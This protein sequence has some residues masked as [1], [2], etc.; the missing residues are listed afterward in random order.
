MF[1]NSIRACSIGALGLAL[2]VAP[3]IV[4]AT[5]HASPHRLDVA[6]SAAPV[7][8]SITS[9]TKYI[10]G[11]PFSITGTGPRSSTIQVASDDPGFPRGAETDAAGKWSYPLTD[12]ATRNESLTF[13]FRTID[14][15]FERITFSVDRDDKAVP[16][17]IT[18]GTKYIRGEAFTITGTGPRSSTVEIISAETGFSR[19]VKTDADGNWSY[20]LN[21]SATRNDSLTYHF[22]THLG[23]FETITFTVDPDNEPVP[24]AITSGTTYI[25]GEPFTVTGT[26]P[27][28]NAIE[29][30]SA[31][32]GFSRTAK[33]DADG[34]WAHE[35]NDSA[36]RKDSLTYHFRSHLGAFE[37]VT[38]T[39]DP[40]NEPVPFAVTSGT[41]YIK[42]E[43]FMVTGTAPRSSKLEVVS[44]AGFATLVD[45]STDGKWSYM[46]NEY[47]T[48]ADGLALRFRTH[49][50]EFKEIAFTADPD[51]RAVPLAVT[52]GVT[53]T[54]GE[55]FTLTGTAPRNTGVAISVPRG[56]ATAETD[57][58]G[59]WSYTLDA[60]LTDTDSIAVGLDNHL[61]EHESVTLQA[62]PDALAVTSGR[63]YTKGEPLTVTG[64][65]PRS[66][67]LEISISGGVPAVIGIRADGTWAYELGARAT[68]VDE[69]VLGLRPN[70]GDA[71]TVMLAGKPSTKPVPFAVTS[72]TEYVQ[73]EPFTITGTGPRSS[74]IDVFPEYLELTRNTKTDADGKWSY[75]LN[76]YLTRF[77]SL[78]FGFRTVAGEHQTIT[79]TPDPDQKAV[80]FA[81]TSDTTYGKG[82]AFTITGTA[83]RSTTLEI[84]NE[85]GVT[86]SVA[87]GA[88]GTWK[89]TLNESAT[90][91]DRFTLRFRTH[92]D[93]FES[94]TFTADPA[95]QPAPV[96]ITS[97][98]TYTKGEAFTI[99]GTAKPKAEIGVRIALIGPID[100]VTADAAGKWSLAITADQAKEDRLALVLT[101]NGSDQRHEFTAR[102][103]ATEPA[104]RL[105]SP[106]EYTKGQKITVTGK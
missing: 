15:E 33:T 91:R 18:S 31:E 72:G 57:A 24:F 11:E 101:A 41:T 21:D 81:I 61:G 37:T 22:R 14:D 102:D 9:G 103:E 38:F 47:A 26:G 19:T 65:G 73:G 43:P 46:L 8:F 5:A 75:Q 23:E 70:S 3:V 82:D 83:P 36:T 20:Q 92:L 85:H 39:V 90:N 4:P 27:R 78:T 16:L 28:S 104:L 97:G 105:T 52:S 106:T 7:P 29:I 71:K 25:K 30:I 96:V 69:L 67:P 86:K 95:K 84:T 44:A 50:G 100:P 2:I 56:S 59:N 1:P 63:S 93:H 32:T 66:T 12:F 35:L 64:T 68:D 51:Q 58:D 54:R 60:E 48:N 94:V 53:Y 42:G 55:P 17:S 99:A 10:K 77:D 40:D 88:D 79:F 74:T 87:T 98:T 34:K 6:S 80:P 62:D 45:T 49:L 89:H 13:D 76:E